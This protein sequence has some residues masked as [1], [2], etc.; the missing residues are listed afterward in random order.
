VSQTSEASGPAAPDQLDRV[1]D[2]RRSRA[3]AAWLVPKLCRELCRML[4]IRQ[5]HAGCS[6][7][8]HSLLTWSPPTT[9][10]N[11]RLTNT[12]PQNVEVNPVPS[13]L[14]FSFLYDSDLIIRKSAVRDY[15]CWRTDPVASGRA[16]RIG[17]LI[18]VCQTMNVNHWIKSVYHRIPRVV[19]QTSEAAG[20]AAPG[21]SDRV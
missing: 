5:W 21:Q 20:P 10:L 3:P 4:A 8:A 19:S 1:G 9:Q 17:P 15:F 12:E 2:L 14:S 16:G 7:E 13:R 11:S 18:P 6:H